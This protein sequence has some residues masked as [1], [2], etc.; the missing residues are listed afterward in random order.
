MRDLYVGDFHNPEAEKESWEEYI[1][2]KQKEEESQMS[3]TTKLF[4]ITVFFATMYF[5][6]SYLVNKE[7]AGIKSDI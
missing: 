3:S 1:R 7:N 2:R 4:L 5:M 6:Y